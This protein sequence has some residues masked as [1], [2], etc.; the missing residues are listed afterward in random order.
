MS[1]KIKF[2]KIKKILNCA[3]KKSIT[4]QIASS[5]LMLFIVGTSVRTN[6]LQ[7]KYFHEKKMSVY[8]YNYN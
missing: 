1:S 6:C 2:L 8:L 4:C 3:T 7:F 5:S